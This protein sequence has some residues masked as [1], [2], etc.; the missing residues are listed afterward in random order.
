MCSLLMWRAA[1]GSVT[2][3]LGQLLASRNPDAGFP[4]VLQTLASCSLTFGIVGTGA[5]VEHI[6]DLTVLV[7]LLQ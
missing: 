3:S 4:S 2:L 1:A 5:L 7:S 6:Q